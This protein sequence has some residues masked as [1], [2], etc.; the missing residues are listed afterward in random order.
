[1]MPMPPLPNADD[2]TYAQHQGWACCWCHASLWTVRGGI[3][4]GRARGANG[5]IEVYACFTCTHGRPPPAPTA[6]S[7]ASGPTNSRPRALNR[8]RPGL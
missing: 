2:L 7:V 1:M 3:S 6:E 5:S 8:G 4:V